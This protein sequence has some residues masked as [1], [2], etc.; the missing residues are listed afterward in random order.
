MNNMMC[1]DTNLIVLIEVVKM[2]G[3]SHVV[4]SANGNR[5]YESKGYENQ[6]TKCDM[7]HVVCKHIVSPPLTILHHA[8]KPP[9][10]RVSTTKSTMLPSS[11]WFIYGL[12]S[13][14]SIE[15]AVH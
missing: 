9:T 1:C 5:P 8:P 3:K 6:S 13:V 11:Q 14:M 4:G 7:L 15:Y 2:W 12:L 10:H